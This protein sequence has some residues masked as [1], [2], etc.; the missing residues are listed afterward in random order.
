MEQIYIKNISGSVFK[1]PFKLNT[2]YEIKA[3]VR[4]IIDAGKRKLIPA[5]VAVWLDMERLRTF[6]DHKEIKVTIRKVRVPRVA[7]KPLIKANTVMKPKE[8]VPEKARVTKSEKVE[9]GGS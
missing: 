2:P 3:K 4:G 5:E 1:I 7:I 8:A 6:E 9:K